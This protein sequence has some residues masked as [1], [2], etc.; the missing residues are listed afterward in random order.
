MVPLP[1]SSCIASG[2]ILHCAPVSTLKHASLPVGMVSATVQSMAL[3]CKIVLIQKVSATSSTL[4]CL[5]T[6]AK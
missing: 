5:H 4:R 1:S 2:I 3:F 6:L